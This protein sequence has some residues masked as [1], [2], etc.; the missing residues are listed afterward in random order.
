M[1]TPFFEIFHHFCFFVRKHAVEILFY[2][3]CLADS[4]GAFHAVAGD[5]GGFNTHIP[6][7]AHNCPG[8]IAHFVTEGEDSKYPF[9]APYENGRGSGTLFRVVFFFYAFIEWA[10]LIFI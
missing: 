7:T 9:V 6:E 1:V 2:A 3:N 10:A 8:F 4:F 5:H